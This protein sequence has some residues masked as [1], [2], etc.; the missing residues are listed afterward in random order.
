M[1]VDVT[2]K[3]GGKLLEN[4]QI[5]LEPEG[6]SELSWT[7]QA[8]EDV[9]QLVWEFVAKENGTGSAKDALKITQQIAPAVPVTVQQATF[10]RIDGKYE[11]PV[12]MPAGAL[13][14]K[15]GFEIG[16]SPKLS[17][18]PPGLKRFFEEYPFSC[19]EQKTSIAVGLHDEKRWQEIVGSL[20][21]YLDSDGLA[22]Y[23]P[24]SSGSV[25]L[26]AYL[27]DMSSL[28]GFALPEDV[29]TR[30]LQG[31]TAFTEGRIKQT[32]YWSPTDDL[33]IRKLTALEAITRQG[34]VNAG[35]TR[36]AAAIDPELL[37]LPTAALIDWTLVI[38]RLTDLPQR[39]TKLAA[40]EQELRN[41]LSY[42]G[43]R[44]GFTTEKSDFWWWM[45][46]SGDSNAFRLIEAMLDQPSWQDDLPKLMRGAIERQAHGRWF[47]TTAN[48][49]A[50]ITLQK[51][52]QKF[53]RDAVTGVTKATLGTAK[54]EFNWKSLNP[55]VPQPPLSLPWPNKTGE[56]K[57]AIAH[58]GTGKPW[59][60]VQVL[61]AI[62][63]GAPRAFGYKLT[64]TVVPLQEKVP[65]KVSRGDLWRV[66]INVEAD[67]DMTWVVVSDP[68]PAGARILG[69]GD[70]RD[71]HI[72]TMD[73]DVR[74]RRLWPTFVERT[75][76][77]FRAYYE[78]VP[79][80]RF[81]IDYTVRINNAGE[82]SLPPTRVEAMY[83]PDVFGELPNA[84]VV[85][86]N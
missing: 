9:T 21:A 25:S 38:R 45:M 5:K 83:A 65:G 29:K 39:S 16:L 12:T 76:G 30:M 40:A 69:D 78:V 77:F 75:F 14:G 22:N 53:E 84:K 35:P 47:T 8:P 19:L 50:A 34:I 24:G 36:V 74:S 49:W 2:A 13:P 28:S 79:T 17:T 6:A 20:P 52:G 1:T 51:F 62:P 58:E 80:G 33:L 11:V 37:R 81:Q 73:E 7:T 59:A 55:D 15:G 46:V 68:I 72:A 23:F 32:R 3:V 64:R 44:L 18:P 26:T 66:T 85:V 60:S 56:G 48:T 31:L 42:S 57:L 82:F 41:R 54:S 70:G 4:R 71:S 27:L 43:G 67:Q 10:T 63:T 61:A 86:G